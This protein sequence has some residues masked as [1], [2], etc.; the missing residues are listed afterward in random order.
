MAAGDRE[1]AAA[2]KAGAV[3]SGEAAGAEEVAEMG[4]GG[5]QVRGA[6]GNGPRVAR[7]KAVAA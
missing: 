5:R 7:R 1:Q 6:D 2:G 3:T 4:E